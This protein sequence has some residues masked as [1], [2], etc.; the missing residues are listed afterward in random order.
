[1]SKSR[2]PCSN[3]NHSCNFQPPKTIDVP[4]WFPQMCHKIN[5]ILIDC[6]ISQFIAGLIK[7]LHP[8]VDGMG[9]M[10]FVL[11][12]IQKIKEMLSSSGPGGSG[13][14]KNLH[15]LMC[16][17]E[18][19]FKSPFCFLCD[20]CGLQV[21]Q[22]PMFPCCPASI[23]PVLMHV[24]ASGGPAGWRFNKPWWSRVFGH[25]T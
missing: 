14:F 6:T 22:V 21:V 23:N 24:P 4:Q 11:D 18:C 8:G 20:I 9:D 10:D 17:S 15:P 25:L 12:R 7:D 1:M 13:V 16:P 3:C 2:L 19:S 5:L